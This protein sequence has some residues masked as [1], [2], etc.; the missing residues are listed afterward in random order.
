M[1]YAAPVK[2]MRFVLDTVTPL[3]GTP[4]EGVF[5]PTPPNPTT[6]PLV[7]YPRD[8]LIPTTLRVEQA[9]KIVLSGG[10]V[11]PVDP[12]PVGPSPV[13]PGSVDPS[14]MN[15]SPSVPGPPP[16]EKGAT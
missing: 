4:L 8:Q 13:N 14:P 2:D 5:I 11:V 3:V 15:P 9:L 16:S 1:P 7:Y 10:A 12:S 6:G